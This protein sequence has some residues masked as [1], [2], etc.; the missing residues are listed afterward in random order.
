[1]AGVEDQQ[2]GHGDDRKGRDLQ[3]G[4]GHGDDTHRPGAD[5]V[6]ERRKPEHGAGHGERR[7]PTR[8]EP[9]QRLRVAGGGDGDRGMPGPPLDPVR[10]GGEE[11]GEPAERVVSVGVWAART[12]SPAHEPRERQRERE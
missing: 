8:P 10:P 4:R 6:V 11:S 12:P 2:S 1:V 3:D 9:E 5:E 7:Q